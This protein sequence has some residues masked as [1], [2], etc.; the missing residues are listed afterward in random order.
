MD[1]KSVRVT[2]MSLRAACAEVRLLI[3]V[4]IVDDDSESVASDHFLS[5]F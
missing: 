1:A 2:R 5:F 3:A 4:T